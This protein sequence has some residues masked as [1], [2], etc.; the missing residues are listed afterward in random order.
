MS[1]NVSK[2]VSASC[3]PACEGESLI[4]EVIGKEHP[5]GHTFRIFDETNNEQQEWLKKQ[6]EVEALDD[7]VLHVWPWKR[8][9]NRN[10]WMD[11][12][13]EEG[14]AIRVALFEGVASTKREIEQQRN[15]ISPLVPLTLIHDPEPEPAHPKEH[16]VPV[17]PG[18]IYVFRRGRLWRELEVLYADS[19][20]MEFRDVRLTDY[21]QGSRRDLTEDRRPAV[22]KAQPAIW[23]PV[24][25]MS[26]SLLPEF[27]MAFSEVQWSA[28]RIAY[29]EVSDAA[30]KE[31]CQSLEGPEPLPDEASKSEDREKPGRL[32]SLLELP[33]MRLREPYLEQ[34][35]ARP[36]MSV[37]DLAG[38]H[39]QNLY[40][41]AR[42][43][44]RAFAE[45]KESA[46][47]ALEKASYRD[48]ALKRAPSA[49]LAALESQL[50]GDESELWQALGKASDSLGEPRE[51]G[52]WGVILQ[53]HLFCV[54]HHVTQALSAQSLIEAVAK[55]AQKS[56]H[57]ASAQLVQSVILPEKLGGNKNPLNDFACHLDTTYFGP[58]HMV[59]R[60]AQRRI[61][62]EELAR[63]QK[64]VADTIRSTEYQSA[65]ADLFTLK[66]AD[67]LEGFSVCSNIFQVLCQ[68]PNDWDA[69]SERDV[70]SEYQVRDANDLLL[71]II[72]EGSDQPL[73]AMIFPSDELLVSRNQPSDPEECGDGRCRPNDLKEISESLPEVEDSQSL[74]AVALAALAKDEKSLELVTELKRWS[75]AV[76][77]LL[78]G[79]QKHSQALLN[80]LKSRAYSLTGKF[81]GPLL[82]MAKARDPNLF[83]AVQLVARNAV[84]QGWLIIGVVDPAIGLK[85]GVTQAD[86]EYRHK[87]NL[88]KRFYGEFYNSEGEILASTAK[89]R[90][91]PSADD[92]DPGK[93][94]H[95]REVQVFAAPADSEVI[96]THRQLRSTTK[97]ERFF[98]HARIPY[99]VF[100]IE[101]FNIL[102][103]RQLLSQINN[104]KGRARAGAGIVSAIMDLS[105]AGALA[106]ERA[107]KDL[108]MWKS[109][110]KVLDRAWIKTEGTL[111]VR[112]FP[113]LEKALP[114]V[115]TTRVIGGIATG[116]LAVLVS[117]LDLVHEIDTGDYDAAAAYGISIVGTGMTMYGGM[118]L[119]HVAGNGA[120]WLALAGP[121]GWVALGLT[122]AIAGGVAAVFLDDEPLEEWL[123][124][125]PFGG[126]SDN[127]FKHLKNDPDESFYRLT[128]LLSRPRIVVKN[129]HN[130]NSNVVK[131]GVVLTADQD[132]EFSKVNTEV[133]IENNLCG[134]LDEVSLRSELRLVEASYKGSNWGLGSREVTKVK[135]VKVVAEES[136]ASGKK[137]YLVLPER[138][139]GITVSRIEVRAQWSAIWNGVGQCLKLV[140]PAPKLAD[141]TQF[142]P[143]IHGEPD[144]TSDNLPFWAN[145]KTH[146]IS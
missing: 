1:D 13:A 103:E 96:E 19:G 14:A 41:L 135:D 129:V 70:V 2:P 37:Y 106:A 109:V 130:F 51:A 57:I 69:E 29:L 89:S 134:L 88:H 118:L 139:P 143:E 54:R 128:N 78:D 18:F 141:D 33:E 71:R 59:L 90:L 124:R 34:N 60:S 16:I 113:L 68:N 23:I 31:R 22:G 115:I 117:A 7:S 63:A 73:H 53:D 61:A 48:A 132:R 27:Q 91:G 146:G 114:K 52:C 26:R 64:L 62:R 112:F 43:E 8:E 144:F 97:W 21:R 133:T 58:L 122:L 87:A 42:E 123:K 25:E 136:N 56:E 65:L 99:L 102:N 3:G 11:I 125:G 76:N 80:R 110:P 83:D 44:A 108:A 92:V 98:D 138:R 47:S 77:T 10:L 119:A 20:V 82:R 28:Q 32:I 17:R 94:R 101:T 50:G 45:N 131:G 74:T 9:P 116:G 67:Y 4:V 15:R 35:L 40:S 5:E 66:K 84:P 24:S 79:L 38:Q 36:W 55:L 93:T 6:V 111:I 39:S 72:E 95:A 142:D 46:S 120:G 121:W 75:A 127:E 85:N 49:R 137:L 12:A 105:F 81:Y 104:D 100:F 86:N 140:F 126:E 107:S 145:Q 30:R